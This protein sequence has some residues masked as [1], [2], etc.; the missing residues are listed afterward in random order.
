MLKRDNFSIISNNS[1]CVYNYAKKETK[2]N[3]ILPIGDE[4]KFLTNSVYSCFMLPIRIKIAKSLNTYEEHFNMLYLMFTEYPEANIITSFVT[5]ASKIYRWYVAYLRSHSW[6]SSDKI[7]MKT[8]LLLKPD[9][10]VSFKGNL[11][12]TSHGQ[13]ELRT[14]DLIVFSLREV[15]LF[16]YLFLCCTHTWEQTH[17]LY[18]RSITGKLSFFYITGWHG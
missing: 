11:C 9:A 16:T 2:T 12:W 3:I 14:W 4:W 17:F 6:L 18:S 7:H 15:G 10:I 13:E 8:F 1:M 5:E